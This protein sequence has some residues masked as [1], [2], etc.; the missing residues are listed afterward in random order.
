MK[1]TPS[2]E[3]QERLARLQAELAAAGVDAALLV[4][5]PDVFYLSG[6]GQQGHLFVPPQGV[7]LLFVKKSLAR[8]REE[9]PLQ[10][11]LPLK[12]ASDLPE[13]LQ[14]RGY[15]QFSRLGMELDVLPAAQ[16]LR[17]QQ[18]FAPA[19]IVDISPL[20]RRLRMVK[21]PFEL[22]LMRD[23]AAVAQKV[24]QAALSALRP[25]ITEVELA[26]VLEYEA[27]RNGHQGH[28]RVRSFNQ[29]LHFGHI[30]AGAGATV[31]SYFDG[32]T[33]G[34]GLNPSLPHGAGL[35]PIER[36]E[37]VVLDITVATEGYIVDQTRVI[38]L[39][40]PPRHLL[41]AHRLALDIESK[42]AAVARPGA[43]CEELYHVAL[44]EVEAAGLANHFMGFGADRA[45]FLG[46]GVGLELDEWPV[47]ARGSKQRLVAG[48]TVAM[49][50]KFVFPGEGVVGIEDTFLVTDQGMQAI[51]IPP[52][53]I[54]VVE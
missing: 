1:L 34:S 9:S 42:V 46:H 2:G 49:E 20:L 32:P 10:E 41:D 18:L 44:Q 54:A 25:G 30:M 40:Q 29:E 43:G 15:G 13:A 17:Y 45:P 23:A 47:L 6:S 27:R 21:S 53:E 22:A 24:Y 26:A 35:R 7:P 36:G 52:R 51:T 12:G 14:Q 3:I 16:Y 5:R 33:G 38:C 19:E 39:G 48:M 28:T 37:P 11:V 4:Q 50:P 8:A 31:P